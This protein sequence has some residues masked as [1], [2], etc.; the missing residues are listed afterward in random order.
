MTVKQAREI[1]AEPVEVGIGIT[2]QVLVGADE[3]PNFSMRKFTIEPGG[4]MPP[5]TN[6]VE[7]EQYVLRGKAQIGI[8]DDI[9]E[10]KKD[11][12]VYIPAGV[13]HWYNPTGEEPFEFICIVP[14][15]PDTIG[16][17]ELD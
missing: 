10:V 16:L 17:V 5:H 3:A 2:R 7:H 9:I 4:S 14:N 6:T 15:K 12:V 8:G 1:A 13:A 11:D